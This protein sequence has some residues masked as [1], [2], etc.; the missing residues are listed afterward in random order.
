[1]AWSINILSVFIF[2]GPYSTV[3]PKELYLM[4]VGGYGNSTS[5]LGM[6]TDVDLLDP[7]SPESHCDT[8]TSFPDARY[9]MIGEFFA[10][11]PVICGG[12]SQDL[13][14]DKDCYV[15]DHNQWTNTSF[16]L[17]AVRAQA[18]SVVI[19]DEMMWVSG[20]IDGVGNETTYK[21]SDIIYSSGV[22]ESG[23]E[24]PEYIAYHCAAK[25]NSSHIFVAGNGHWDGYKYNAYIIDVTTTPFTFEKL[26][27]MLHSRWGS[28]CASVNLPNSMVDGNDED[29]TM[30]MV[31][32]GWDHPSWTEMYSFSENRWI[33][34]PTLPRDFS[35]GGYVTYPDD[36]GFVLIGGSTLFLEFCDDIM[37]YNIDLNSFEILPSKLKQGREYFGAMLVEKED[38]C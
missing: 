17:T 32:G 36:R 13:G 30:L 4:A 22:V 7:F 8:P 16:S 19:N 27:S 25:I 5:L 23:V 11:Y 10:N 37:W 2:L 31:V 14:Y 1:M 3:H 28:A 20:G 9:G 34:G 6:I 35:A 18:S 24:M 12:Y 21:T 33:D 26:P 38:P 29:N 15:Y